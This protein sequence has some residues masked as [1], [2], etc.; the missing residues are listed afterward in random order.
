MREF[1]SNE[2]RPV[3][4]IGLGN[5]SCAEIR[6]GNLTLLIHQIPGE[7]GDEPEVK[8]TAWHFN[9]THSW[10]LIPKEDIV[11]PPDPNELRLDRRLTLKRLP[12]G[13][14][15]LELCRIIVFEPIDDGAKTISDIFEGT[16]KQAIKWFND[17]YEWWARDNYTAKL[18]AVPA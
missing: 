3:A 12:E 1:D 5:A 7:S 18:M 11:I 10:T 9:K 6:M 8:I 16:P 13:F 15:D 2:P 17:N 4:V 14:A